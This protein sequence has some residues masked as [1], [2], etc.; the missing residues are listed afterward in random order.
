MLDV[1]GVKSP[2]DLKNKQSGCH[3]DG[4]DNDSQIVSKFFFLW[5]SATLEDSDLEPVGNVS[6]GHDSS[7]FL[8]LGLHYCIVSFVLKVFFISMSAAFSLLPRSDC[9]NVWAF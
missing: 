9:S 1:I 8:S 4:D 7:S 6:S 2:I 5:A 3:D